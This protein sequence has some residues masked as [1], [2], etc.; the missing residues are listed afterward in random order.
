MK[1]YRY[2]IS[3]IVAL[4]LISCAS[5]P[6]GPVDSFKGRSAERIFNDAEK[7]LAKKHYEDAINGFEALDIL[8]PF[9]KYARQGQLDV[10]YAYYKNDDM[11]SAIAAAGRYIH[12]YPA[13]SNVDYAYYLKGLANFDKTRSWVDGIYK[14]DP[15]TRD[16]SSMRAAF[17]DFNDLLAHF[18]NSKYASDARNRMLY[19]RNLIA[20]YELSIAE[21]YMRRNAY[22]A[23]I[24]RASYIVAHLDGAPQVKEALKIMINGYAK[25]GATKEAAESQRVFD[26]NFSKS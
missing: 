2:I 21:Y 12:L 6:A 4:L 8:H 13:N 7:A 20:K 11:D 3:S 16:L 18:P 22:V 14:R 17:V 23:A 9:G 25:L 19:I 26:M 1:I 5:E 15:S 10:I 24:N